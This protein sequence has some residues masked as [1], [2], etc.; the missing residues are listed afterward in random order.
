[1]TPIQPMVEIILK[2]INNQNPKIRYGCLYCIAE[3]ASNLKD[4]FTEIYADQVVPA[5]CRYRQF[6]FAAWSLQYPDHQLF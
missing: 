6:H 1:M 2:D 3:F 4:E 5:F